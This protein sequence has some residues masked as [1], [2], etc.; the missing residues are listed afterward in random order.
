MKGVARISF[1]G[2]ALFIPVK[3]P[4]E[5]ELLF[6]HVDLYTKRHGQVRIE[7]NRREWVVSAVNGE[8]LMRCSACGRRLDAL[9]YAMGGRTLCAPCARRD[10]R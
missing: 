3:T 4:Y 8:Q 10:L 7:F 2:G 1:Q 9:T 5:R 6:E